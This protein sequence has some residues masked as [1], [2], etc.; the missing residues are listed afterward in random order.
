VRYLSV[1]EVLRFHLIV[2]ERSGGAAGIRDPAALESALAQPKMT[3]GGTD[4]Y[5]SIGE[6]AAAL[7]FFLVQNHPFVD[8]NKRTGH[9]AMDGFLRFNGFQIEAPVGEQ[10]VLVLALA[11]GEVQIEACTDWVKA[12]LGPRVAKER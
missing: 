6:K 10:E 7:C 12:H 11:A 5:P 9:A 4:L 1:Q 8:G 3:F 2:T